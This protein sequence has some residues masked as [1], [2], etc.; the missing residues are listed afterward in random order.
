MFDIRAWGDRFD[1]LMSAITFAEA[2][3]RETAMDFLNKMQKKKR[4]VLKEKKQA[5]QRPILRV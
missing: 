1:R 4:L 3:Q 2:G 5:A